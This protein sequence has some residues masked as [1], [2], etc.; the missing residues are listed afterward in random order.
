M[1][2]VI[3]NSAVHAYYEIVG[4]LKETILQS[5]HNI[6]N[7]TRMIWLTYG[8]DLDGTKAKQKEANAKL[9]PGFTKMTIW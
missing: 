7:C 6:K 4:R 2:E 3:E 8:L 9:A 1:K 5:Y